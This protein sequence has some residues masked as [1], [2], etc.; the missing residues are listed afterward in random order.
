MW[1]TYNEINN[2]SQYLFWSGSQSTS[3]CDCLLLSIYVHRLF[4]CRRG[5]LLFVVQALLILAYEI[6]Q[7]LERLLK[8]AIVSG[9]G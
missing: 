1:R 8:R 5:S 7:G 3:T 6:V 2:A 4:R 9:R